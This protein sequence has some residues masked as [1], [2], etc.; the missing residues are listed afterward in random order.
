MKATFQGTADMS[1]NYS[2]L[3]HRNSQLTTVRARKLLYKNYSMIA[4]VLWGKS[5]LT[6]T[7]FGACILNNLINNCVSS[8]REKDVVGFCQN[9]CFMEQVLKD[10]DLSRMVSRID[11]GTVLHL[12][13]AYIQSKHLLRLKFNGDD[14][15]R[16][17]ETFELLG[18]DM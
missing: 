16:S 5:A 8:G 6:L 7:N 18:V 14:V 17:I 9:H 15:K 12:I 10:D 3:T 13:G 11:A 4:W 2:H 1:L